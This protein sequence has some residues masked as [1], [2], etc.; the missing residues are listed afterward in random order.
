MNAR[1]L[2]VAAT[3]ADGALAGEDIDR[4]VMQWPAYRRIGAKR[5]AEY[6]RHADLTWRGALLYPTESIGGTLLSI[7]TAVAIAR[8]RRARKVRIASAV[9]AI[10]AAGGLA[11]TLQAAPNMLSLR[12]DDADPQKA[13]D[14]FRFWSLIRGACQ[15]SAF[16]ANV[17]TLAMM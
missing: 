4:M 5:W 1:T 13:F 3:L 11:L 12:R 9:A 6:S 10:F 8:S 14:G 15:V 7:A 2:A 16:V 17:A